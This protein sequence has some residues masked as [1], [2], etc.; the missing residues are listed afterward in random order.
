VAKRGQIKTTNEQ[1]IP[2]FKFQ[3]FHFFDSSFFELVHYAQ[4]EKSAH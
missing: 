1:T 4:N 2:A 3:K